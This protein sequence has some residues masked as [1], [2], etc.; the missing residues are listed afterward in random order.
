MV[1]SRVAQSCPQVRQGKVLWYTLTYSMDRPILESLEWHRSVL[2]R[3]I[4]S[5]RP[6]LP[7]T[8]CLLAVPLTW[9]FA[10]AWMSLQSTSAFK[11]PCTVL[12]LR[13]RAGRLSQPKIKLQV[14]TQI[15][16]G[17]SLLKGFCWPRRTSVWGHTSCEHDL[18]ACL[19]CQLLTKCS[20]LLDS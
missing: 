12:P 14:C 4:D 17:A 3:K 5:F 9:H 15:L 19:R 13:S 7:P 10:R 20:S 2:E 11:M 6:T 8:G 1:A 18:L 16:T